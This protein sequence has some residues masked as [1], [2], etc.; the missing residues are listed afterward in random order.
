MSDLVRRIGAVGVAIM[1]LCALAACGG[2]PTS[3]TVQAG[4]PFTDEPVGDFVFIPVGPTKDADQQ[5]ILDGFIAAFTGPQGDYATAREFLSTEF[6]KE[7]D[8]RQSVLIRTGVPTVR[9]IDAT[10]LE[11][12]FTAT[13]QLDQF[14]AYTTGTPATQALQFQFVQEDGQW[15]ISQAPPGIVLAESTFLTIFSKHALYFYDLSLRHLVPDQRWFPG[16][17][18]ATRVV[19]ALLAGPPEWL[20]GAVVTQIPDGTQLTPG[21]TV[22][23]DSTVAQVDLTND[24]AAADEHQ[25]QLMQLQLTESLGTVSGIGSVELSV[26]GT[27]LTIEPF[28]SDQP[29]AQSPVDQRPLVLADGQFGYYSSGAITPVD[30]LSEKIVGLSPAAVVLGSR[31]T[32]AAVLAA[33]GVYAVRAGEDAPLRADERSGLVAPSLDDYGYVWSVPVAS[34]SAFVA[35]GPDGA[36]HPVAVTLP[37]DT[38]VRSFAVSRDNARIAILLQTPVGA[39]LVVAAIARDAGQDYLPTGI[40]AP[41]I[42]SLLDDA[43]AVGVTW[44]D[45]FSVAVLADTDDVDLVT[46]FEVG[47]QRSS[48][49]RAESPAVTSVGGSSKSGLRL[50][51]ADGFLQS[52][53]GSG[54]QKT[55]VEV[56]LL[57]TQR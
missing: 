46:S 41:V 20:R 50:L 44:V 5:G 56:E 8:P 47:G 33:D 57:A 18:T 55:G 49:G 39:R 23:I 42:S 45:A 36:A 34:P 53:R 29:V 54:W 13:A 9:T 27:L 25:R 32:A 12:S 7:W 3:G 2:I 51:G 24:A 19:T 11:Y 10:T 14:G 43:S 1:L 4:D 16:G 15:R 38:R 28:G 6:K 48:L 21:T 17:T 37:P 30:D 31:G 35:F 26:S 22:T 52:P 40:G